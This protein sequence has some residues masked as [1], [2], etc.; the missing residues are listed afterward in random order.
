MNPIHNTPSYFT[1]RSIPIY[2]HFEKQKV[3][4]LGDNCRT[5]GSCLLC[6][7][8]VSNAQYAV[9]AK[10]AIIS[11]GSNQSHLEQASLRK[12]YPP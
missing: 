4:L 8:V 12:A 2:L 6:G 7:P 11:T 1:V 10:K 3:L 9:K 5:V